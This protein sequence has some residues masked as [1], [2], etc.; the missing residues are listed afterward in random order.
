MLPS[1]AALRA[2]S[3]GE[4]GH[5]HHQP[6]LPPRYWDGD[7]ALFSVNSFCFKYDNCPEMAPRPPCFCA[8]CGVV[9]CLF[10]AVLGHG[11][12]AALLRAHTWRGEGR[13]VCSLRRHKVTGAER[14]RKCLI[15]DSY[16]GSSEITRRCNT[17][18]G[19]PT[20][21]IFSKERKSFSLSVLAEESLSCLPFSCKGGKLRRC[22][23]M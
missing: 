5:G 12:I 14:K 10:P 3:Q 7:A 18:H 22:Q 11:G 1:P 8:C 13:G 19:I 23:I 9:S 21:T 20:G 17:S 15:I 16:K 4:V 6:R 2:P